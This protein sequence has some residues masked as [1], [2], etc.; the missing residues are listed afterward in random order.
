MLFKKNAT[1][2]FTLFILIFSCSLAKSQGKELSS[3]GLHVIPYPQEVLLGGSPFRFGNQTNIVLDQNHSEQDRFAAEELIQGLKNEFNSI[4]TISDKK[5][6]GSIVLTRKNTLPELGDQG[7]QLQIN[8]EEIVVNANSSQG[9]FYGAQTLLQLIQKKRTGFEIAGMEINDWPDITQ[10]SIHYDTKHHQDKM[11]YVKSFIRDLARY[12]INMM[13]WE[14]EDK[15]AYPSHKEVGAPGAFTSKEMQEITKYAKKYYVQLVP[16]VQGLGHVSFILKWPKHQ[17][18]REVSASNWEFCPLKEGTYDLMFDLWEDAIKATPGSEYIHIGSDETYE[19]GMCEACKAKVKE[20][21]KSGLYLMFVNKAA[22]HLQKKGRKVIVW[23]KPMKWEYSDS[24]AKGI[25]PTKGLIFYLNKRTAI[26]NFGNTQKAK[27]LGY[28][29]FAYDPNPGIEPLFLPYYL[30]IRNGKKS[31]SSLENSYSHISSMAISKVFDGMINTSWDDSG[32]HNQM[33][34]MGF[35]LSAEYAWSGANPDLDQFKESFFKNYYGNT[36]VNVEE[37]FML[38]N[39]GSYYYWQTFERQVWHFKNVGKT[40]LPDLP[41]GDALEYNPFWNAE[42]RD[43]VNRSKEQLINMD[44]VLQIVENNKILNAK[45]QYDFELF[46]TIA[47][48]IRHT[49]LTYLDLSEV[50][51]EIEEAHKNNFINRELAYASLVKAQKIIEN[52]LER[53]QVV[54]TDLVST[55]EKTRL[56]KGLSTKNKPYFHRQDRARHFANRTP[57]MTYLIH[58]EQR[59]D[60]EGYLEKLKVYTNYYKTTIWEPEK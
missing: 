27:A 10:R 3:L 44:R 33:W 9:L 24:P 14:W 48:L 51:N 34:M 2:L 11:T 35:V 38:L 37:L 59:L 52:T 1:V 22:E 18:L 42:Y 56:P 39:K 53:R 49:S 23:D 47:Q 13:I 43:M 32:L 4:I 36:S 58:D 57:D 40:H 31:L 26:P 21:G 45:N 12:K 15:L 41:R 5:T 54:F 60:M 20:V 50:E 25:T 28:E 19:L 8:K 55:W 30:R 46:R 17:H 6:L 7:Y 29:T 16:L